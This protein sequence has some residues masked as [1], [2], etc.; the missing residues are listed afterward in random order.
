[1]TKELVRDVPFVIGTASGSQFRIRHPSVAE[2]HAVLRWDGVQ[3]KIAAESDWHRVRVNGNIELYSVRLKDGDSLRIGDFEFLFHD[4]AG[5]EKAAGP[6]PTAV[7]F[8]GAATDEV[9]L[10][11]GLTIGA[12][13]EA[14]VRL[15]DAALLPVHAVIEQGSEG[16][17]VADKGGPGLLLNGRLFDRQ[18]LFIGDRLDVGARHH[19]VFDGRMLH[20][21]P[22]GAGCGL[23]AQRVSVAAGERVLLIDAG[24]SVRPGEFVGV[25]GASGSGKTTLLRALA[26]PVRG[27]KGSVF[28]NRTNRGEIE[29]AGRWIGC[30]PREAIVHAELTGRQSLKWTASLRLPDTTPAMEIAKLIGHLAERLGI[31]EHL[32]TPARDL[33]AHQLKRLCIA[34]ELTGLPPLLLLDDPA[35]GFD[36]DEEEKLLRLLRELTDTGCTI[37]CTT[38]ST[39]GVPLM[40]GIEV[41]ASGGNEA[42]TTIFRG[43]PSA[44]SAHFG[45]E[46]LPGLYG[47]IGE[48]LPS[49]W[50]R[51][52]E[53]QSGQSA[54]A[55]QFSAE[56]VLPPPRP[57]LRGS[58]A[59]STLLRRQL[60]LLASAPAKLLPMLAAPVIISLVI[61]FAVSAERTHGVTRMVLACAAVFMLACW[62]AASDTVRE[63]PIASRERAAGVPL[64]AWLG[65]KLT[66]HWGVSLIQQALLF[67]VLKSAGTKGAA[68]P[69]FLLLGGAGLLA[70]LAAIAA[71]T[72]FM[73][74]RERRG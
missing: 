54:A 51:I 41:L 28:L 60:A 49:E 43:R 18:L 57:R 19:F 11:G 47:K 66:W 56:T 65:A 62:N 1:M 40:D 5:E 36:A 23:T 44:L 7:S 59:F 24:L 38:H 4:P 61:V 48:R 9:A 63:H 74:R 64:E 71:A 34:V 70:T 52:F 6:N 15:D 13:A 50:R 10:S 8:H 32:D 42:G 45:V 16:F 58:A 30:V 53:Q 29:Q 68:L 14:D 55:P 27:M 73:R 69:Q 33:S 67:C 26:G 39:A 21:R 37:L 17:T 72:L 3:T 20:L 31:S 35:A 46:D 25:I 22:H 2:R 12:G